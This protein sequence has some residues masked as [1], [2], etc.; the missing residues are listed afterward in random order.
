[1]TTQDIA[2]LALAILGSIGTAGIIVFAL[3]SWLGKLWANRIMASE[4]QKYEKELSTLRADLERENQKVL[5]GIKLQQ[6]QSIEW[7]K[8]DLNIFK[9][10]HLKGF[11]DKLVCYRELI[12]LI[13]DTLGT[14]D[15]YM[16][17]GQALS[18]EYL[19]NANRQR[20]KIYGYTA[21]IAPQ[22]VMDAQDKLIDY[23]LEIIEGSKPYEWAVVR[24]NALNLI[25]EIRKDIAIDTNP[26]AYNGIR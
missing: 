14:F 12:N 15:S 10:K 7:L 20:L 8:S 13:A 26:I 5:A 17:N 22:S 9:D 1:M 23:L 4:K 25:N 18:Q 6:E 24:N 16:V 11:N 2:N 19:S 21:M 3:S